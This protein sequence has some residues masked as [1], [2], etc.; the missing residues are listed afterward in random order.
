MSPSVK[1]RDNQDWKRE[2]GNGFYASK[3]GEFVKCILR[4][5]KCARENYAPAVISGYCAWCG[6]RE[7]EIKND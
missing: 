1:I 6:H 2:K 5:P 3:D 7:R 4:C